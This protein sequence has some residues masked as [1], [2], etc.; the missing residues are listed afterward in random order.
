MKNKANEFNLLKSRIYGT[1]LIEANA[2]TGKTYTITALFLRLLLERGLNPDNILAVTFTNAAVYELKERIRLR[3]YDALKIFAYNEKL[4]EKVK[5]KF[6]K[7]DPFLLELYENQKD[8]KR[9]FKLLSAA[10]T[11]FDTASVFTIHGFCR[12]ILEENS[13][14]SG[15]L[16]NTL[17]VTETDP[18]IIEIAE[19]FWRKN[20]YNL[21]ALYAAY[22][23]TRLSVNL[24]YGLIKDIN[25]GGL[26]KIL[27]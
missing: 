20:T 11:E 22:L 9:A 5:D 12:R 4:P 2:G 24:L 1:N 19:D 14:E 6:Y 27:M 16:F 10:L 8:K 25:N 17:L 23:K 26:V 15:A 18:F 13:F 21:T 3:I 7:R